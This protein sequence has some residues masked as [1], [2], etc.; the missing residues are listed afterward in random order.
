MARLVLRARVGPET[1]FVQNLCALYTYTK[2]CLGN[3]E[4][5]FSANKTEKLLELL[6]EANIDPTRL[7][8][9]EVKPTV[10]PSSPIPHIDNSKLNDTFRQLKE[11]KERLRIVAEKIQSL[12]SEIDSLTSE[13]ASLE[14]ELALFKSL[15]SN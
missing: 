5:Y 15:I 13:K 2:N 3:Y 8:S 1:L 9:H 12:Q 4:S 10:A 14:A 11:K 7:R 6:R